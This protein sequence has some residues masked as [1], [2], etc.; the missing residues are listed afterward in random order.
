MGE[1]APDLGP[2]GLLRV[3]T[4]IPEATRRALADLGWRLGEPDGGFG[5]Y[6]CIEQRMSGDRRVYGAASEMRADGCAL[7]Y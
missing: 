4:G 3:E 1:D 7:A 6:E 5:R 2:T